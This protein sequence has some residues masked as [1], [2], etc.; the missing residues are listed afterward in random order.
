MSD[1]YFEGKNQKRRIEFNKISKIKE[2]DSSDKLSLNQGSQHRG[3]TEK[4]LLCSNKKTND[5]FIFE[6]MKSSVIA[7]RI[8]TNKKIYQ[9]SLHLYLQDDHQ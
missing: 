8:Y 5:S 7:F 3:I 1:Y 6:I 9:T 2:K 4:N